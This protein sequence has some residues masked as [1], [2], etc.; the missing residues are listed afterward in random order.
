MTL[1]RFVTLTINCKKDKKKVQ[2]H[3]GMKSHQKHPPLSIILIFEGIPKIKNT[4]MELRYA[5]D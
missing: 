1:P 2:T 5:I 4:N 3:F